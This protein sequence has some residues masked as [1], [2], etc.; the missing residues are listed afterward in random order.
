MYTATMEYAFQESNKNQIC[1]LWRNQVLKLAEKQPG[2]IRMQ[3]LCSKTHAMAIGTWEDESYAQD[4]MK[5]G[6]FV[7]LMERFATLLTE[8]PRPRIWELKYFSEA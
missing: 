4:F 5:T 2:F 8:D 6:V 7:K 3:F 1:T